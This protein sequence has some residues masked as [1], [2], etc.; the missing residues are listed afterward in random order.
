VPRHLLAT[1]A[2][3]RTRSGK[4]SES[5]VR[6]ALNGH[7]PQNRLALANPEVLTHLTRLELA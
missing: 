3:P 5:A 1:P 4:L 2:L 7:E 6:A